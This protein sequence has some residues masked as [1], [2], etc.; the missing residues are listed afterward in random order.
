L[1]TGTPED[2]GLHLHAQV[3]GGH[4]AVDLEHLEVTPGVLGH[5]LA[6]SRLW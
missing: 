6:T 5:R 3:V 2:V 1:L 4:A